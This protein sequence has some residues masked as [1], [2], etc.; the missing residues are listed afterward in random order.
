MEYQK[1]LQF[2]ELYIFY[3]VINIIVKNRDLKL[4]KII[5]K[6]NINTNTY[7]FLYLT[8]KYYN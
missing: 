8:R 7:V 5:S 6:L 3:N 4:I 1:L 2:N